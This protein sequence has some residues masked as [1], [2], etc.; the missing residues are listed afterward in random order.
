MML[1]MPLFVARRWL[2]LARIAVVALLAL[3][4]LAIL[5]APPVRARVLAMLISRLERTGIVAHADWIEYNLTTFD[6]RLHRVTLATTTALAT[7]FLTADDVHAALGWGILRGRI[8]VTLFEVTHPRI[9]L[10]RND[11]GVGN[12]PASDQ[13]SAST[14]PVSL[15][16]GRVDIPDLDVMW[17]DARAGLTIDATGLS[18]RL[19]PSGAE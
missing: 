7:P 13:Q 14:S 16:L 8:N 10:V 6:V 17:Q 19:A 4:G 1:G 18:L 9:V 3:V 15:D 11:Q 2:W 5:H 12:W